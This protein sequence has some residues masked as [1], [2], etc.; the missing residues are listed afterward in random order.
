MVYVNEYRDYQWCSIHCEWPK[1][2]RDRNDAVEKLAAGYKIH[3]LGITGWE[4]AGRCLE[5][6]LKRFSWYLHIFNPKGVYL[7]PETEKITDMTGSIFLISFRFIESAWKDLLVLILINTLI[8][9]IWFTYSTFVL[10]NFTNKVRFS[11]CVPSSVV[12][13]DWYRNAKVSASLV[14]SSTNIPSYTRSLSILWVVRERLF[15][16][17]KNLLGHRSTFL[18]TLSL[19]RHLF[20]LTI[21]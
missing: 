21:N 2:L 8:T 1:F 16:Y 13:I 6:F 17:E 10:D 20:S 4:F 18:A 3:S 5:T 12:K 14:L 19:K 9:F 7:S 11:V 15:K